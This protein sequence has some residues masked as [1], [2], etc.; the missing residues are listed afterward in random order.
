EQGADASEVLKRERVLEQ[1]AHTDSAVESHLRA[2][3]LPPKSYLVYAAGERKLY[4]AMN[5]IF[6]HLRAVEV[7]ETSR[8][9]MTVHRKR[10]L[11][12]NEAVQALKDTHKLA[13]QMM[14]DGC[15]HPDTYADW[16]TFV[17]K[18]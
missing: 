7:P 14:R 4:A 2:H 16:I 13:Q 6:P 5:Q 17:Y 8:S 3:G 18:A 1:F 12:Y 15:L 10:T 11:E 9:G